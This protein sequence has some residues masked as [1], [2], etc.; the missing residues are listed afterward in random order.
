MG[1]KLATRRELHF[2]RDLLYTRTHEWARIEENLVRVGLT[3]YAIRELEEITRVILPDEGEKTKQG[4]PFGVVE[5]YKGA[6]DI[7]AP[8]TGTIIEVNH[9]VQSGRGENYDLISQDPYGRGWLIVISPD[10][11]EAEKN[12][13]LSSQEYRRLVEEQL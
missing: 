12:N 6:F 3:S 7:Y 2:P 10:N 4:Q 11:L 13:L 8:F 9:E 5:S 1:V